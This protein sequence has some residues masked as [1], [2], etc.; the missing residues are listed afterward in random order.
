MTYLVPFDGSELSIAA[1]ERAV[2]FAER[3]D[4][5]VVALSVVPDDEVE[6]AI[7]RGWIGETEPF[8]VDSI[9]DGLEAKV[10]ELAPEARFR[11][12]VPPEV[13][14]VASV[15]TDI[16]RTIREV[17]VDEEATV[18]FIGSENAG[19]VS[20]PVSSVGAPVSEDPRYDVHIVRHAGRT[21]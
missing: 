11:A 1:L 3:M 8:D 18:V 20:R 14:S 10:A 9:V 5:D 6:F 7:E 17:A 4:E 16:V 13:S 12:E 2:E 21:G 15:T 19:R